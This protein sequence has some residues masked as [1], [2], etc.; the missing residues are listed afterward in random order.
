MRAESDRLQD[1]DSTLDAGQDASA[2]ARNRRVFGAA[3]TVERYAARKDLFPAE[4]AILARLRGELRGLRMLDLGVGG[5]RTTP[6]FAPAA[7]GYLGVDYAP[8]MV[9]ACRRRF[10]GRLPAEA[11]AVA[12]ARALP[13]EWTGAFGFILF[14]Y[15]GID[16]LDHG[17]R[18]AALSEIAR[19]AAPGA[20]LA[21]SSHNLNA[22]EHPWRRS[23]AGRALAGA[24]AAAWCR[25]ANPGFRAVLAAGRGMLRDTGNRG[26]ARNYYLR[27]EEQ[28]AQAERAGFARV[29]AYPADGETPFRDRTEA[30]ASAAPWIYY[31]GRKAAGGNSAT[32]GPRGD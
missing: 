3:G 4:R 5:G 10:H 12:D 22:L 17:E 20:W 24:L 28:A 13:A 11:F 21:F 27:P 16:F 25:L 14:S 1:A 18:L 8:A 15:N 30:A 26:R 7:A 2:G 32:R 31:L 23:A 29:D 6:H 19:V 9:E